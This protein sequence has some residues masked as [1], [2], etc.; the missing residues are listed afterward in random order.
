MKNMTD[1]ALVSSLLATI[2][3]LL[4]ALGWLPGGLADA[5]IA[6]IGAGILSSI[7]VV[8]RIRANAAVEAPAA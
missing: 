7:A 5:E 6:S 8:A 2:A 4:E 1:G 3:L